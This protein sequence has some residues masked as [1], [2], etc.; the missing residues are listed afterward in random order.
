MKPQTPAG[1]DW[2]TSLPHPNPCSV[3]SIVQMSCYYYYICLYCSTVKPPRRRFW[4]AL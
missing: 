2:I 4:G 3:H 1:V